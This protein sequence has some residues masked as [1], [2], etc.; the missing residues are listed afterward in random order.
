MHAIN[1]LLNKFSF[2][3]IQRSYYATNMPAGTLWLDQSITYIALDSHFKILRVSLSSTNI[4]NK[5]ME[6]FLPFSL[7]HGE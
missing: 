6:T 5:E 1:H 3:F 4:W 7:Q 2:I